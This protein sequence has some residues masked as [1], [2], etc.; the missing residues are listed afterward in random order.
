M[1]SAFTGIL[2]AVSDGP[3]RHFF[4]PFTPAGRAAAGWRRPVVA[5][6]GDQE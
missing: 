6:G 3:L 2:T 1:R 5:G 4:R